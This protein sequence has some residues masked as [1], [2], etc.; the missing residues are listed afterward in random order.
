MVCAC[1]LKF[2]DGLGNGRVVSELRRVGEEPLIPGCRE[3]LEEI[4][5][6]FLHLN[7]DV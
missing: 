2:S 1:P 5:V 7:R 6:P 4:F 3:S